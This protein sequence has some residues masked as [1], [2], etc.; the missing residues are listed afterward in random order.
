MKNY[1][2]NAAADS[3]QLYSTLQSRSYH[4][5][6]SHL[7][8]PHLPQHQLLTP[9]QRQQHWLH[10]LDQFFIPEKGDRGISQQENEI[11]GKFT[12]YSHR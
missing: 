3:H 5:S 9:A 11:S 4:L 2:S 12:R 1:E 6:H 7:Y 10:Q 8:Q